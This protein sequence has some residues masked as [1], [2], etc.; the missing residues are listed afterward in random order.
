[1]AFSKENIAGLYQ[2]RAGW[3][4]FSANTYSLIGFREFAYRQMAVR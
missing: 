2:K 4:D 1:M 3:Y